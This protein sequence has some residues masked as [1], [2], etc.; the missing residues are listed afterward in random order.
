[1]LPPWSSTSLRAIVSPRPVQAQL[2]R[3]VVLLLA[4]SLG[5]AVPFVLAAVAIDWFLRAFQAV[6]RHLVWVERIA[7]ALL[8]VVGVLMITD[9]MTAITTV[10]QAWT[11]AALRRFL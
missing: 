8:V 5:L 1:M 11:P 3:G 2:S 7:G 4:Y 10:L 9:Y 6:R